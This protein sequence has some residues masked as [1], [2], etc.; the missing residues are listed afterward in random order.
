MPKARRAVPASK[1]SAELNEAFASADAR[2]IC[3]A[4]GDALGGFNISEIAR[5]AGLHRPT[6]HRAFLS[7]DK[8]PNFTTVLAVLTAMGLQLQVL[9][10]RHRE[11]P[12]EG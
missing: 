9:P 6:I 8:L 10:R 2:A 11:K 3:G 1:L 5:Q 4:I 12:E 7:N